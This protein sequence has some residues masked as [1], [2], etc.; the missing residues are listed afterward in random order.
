MPEST[1]L[2]YQEVVGDGKGTMV[3]RPLGIESRT[4]ECLTAHLQVKMSL[5]NLLF[6]CDYGH[7]LS[8]RMV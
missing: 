2:Y 1:V 7:F 4:L 5:I 3:D 8:Y 6:M